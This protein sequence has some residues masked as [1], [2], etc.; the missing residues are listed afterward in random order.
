LLNAKLNP[1]KAWD[2]KTYWNNWRRRRL[3]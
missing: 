2:S 3:L 1:L